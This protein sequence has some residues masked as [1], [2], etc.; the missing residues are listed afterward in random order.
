M[1]MNSD[2]LAP[3]VPV[4]GTVAGLPGALDPLG[5]G[6]RPGFFWGKSASTEPNRP[7]FAE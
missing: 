7:A 1:A 4:D 3:V 5:T 6:R 2:V